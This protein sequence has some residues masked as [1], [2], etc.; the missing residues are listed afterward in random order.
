MEAQDLEDPP[1]PRARILAWVVAA[2]LAIGLG[3]CIAKGA[4][5]PADP[6]LA[7]SKFPGFGEVAIQIKGPDGQ[8]LTPAQV[9]AL[10]AASETQHQQGLMN[11]TDLKGYAGMLFRF[12][13]DA[14]A[15]FYMK[16]TL[17][18]LSI[19]WFDASGKF[20][21]ATDMPPCPPGTAA[22]KCPLFSAK[23][24]YRF[25]LEVPQGQLPSLGIG[26]GTTLELAGPCTST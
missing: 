21:S 3:A 14:Q 24:P 11:V 26:P 7:T 6:S 15:S 4:N 18:P 2:L 13:Y 8:R 25:A 16:D 9:C 22:A 12:S 17:I 10:L 19:A 5:Q 20:V 1:D 23:G